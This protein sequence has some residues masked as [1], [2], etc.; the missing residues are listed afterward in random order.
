MG[1]Y[2]WKFHCRFLPEMKENEPYVQIFKDTFPGKR[3]EQM[4]P[5][6]RISY[7]VTQKFRTH[8]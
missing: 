4:H 1:Y 5:R 6:V 2:F 8:W 7:E 3:R